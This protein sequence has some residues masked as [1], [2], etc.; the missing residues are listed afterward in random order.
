MEGVYH[1]KGLYL[2]DFLVDV[3]CQVSIRFRRLA[4]DYSLWKGVVMIRADNDPRRA[5]F[6]VQ[7][8]LNSGTSVFLMI[9]NL[10]DY[11]DVLTCP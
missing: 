8:R 3:L 2:R 10:E 9:G 6:V 4:T 11:F 7:E 1:P 5:E